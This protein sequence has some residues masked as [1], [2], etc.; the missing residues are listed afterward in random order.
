MRKR[1]PINCC[2]IA[3]A[4]AVVRFGRTRL[5]GCAGTA[6]M[7]CNG[8]FSLTVSREHVTGLHNDV[9]SC[10]E[11]SVYPDAVSLSVVYADGQ[12]LSGILIH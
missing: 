4:S 10:G 2:V 12:Y 11:G 1:E 3:E 8:I 9:R 6:R 5:S 7:Q